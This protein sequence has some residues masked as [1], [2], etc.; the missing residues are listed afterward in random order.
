MDIEKRE[1][2]IK[3]ITEDSIIDTIIKLME[4]VESFLDKNGQQKKHY[5]MS[6]LRS[7]LGIE[8]Y[9]RYHYFISS[10]IDFAVGISKGKKLNLNNIKKKYCCF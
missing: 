8:A 10:F 6:E 3:T 9:E 4:N 5:V 7:M 1:L 2:V